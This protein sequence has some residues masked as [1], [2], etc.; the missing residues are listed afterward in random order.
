MLLPRQGI[1]RS[2][3]STVAIPA[4]VTVTVVGFV[5]SVAGMN[6]VSHLLKMVPYKRISH[7][8]VKLPKRSVKG[9]YND[10][11]ILRKMTL[12]PEQY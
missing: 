8:K 12:V 10:Q 3:C 6:C 11:A 4:L 7:E 2:Y 1:R 9:R 5:P